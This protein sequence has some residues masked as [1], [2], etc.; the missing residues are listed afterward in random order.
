MQTISTNAFIELI[1][2]KEWSKIE[3]IR[4]LNWYC[5]QIDIEREII[6]LLT[7]RLKLDRECMCVCVWLICKVNIQTRYKTF[8]ALSESMT[9]ENKWTF[10]TVHSLIRSLPLESRKSYYNPYRIAHFFLFHTA[11]CV[12]CSVK[13][14]TVWC[15]L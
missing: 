1:V 13:Q 8:R 6:C 4:T 2:N 10:I 3:P 14:S 12:R 9:A 15:V 7:R 11:Q 5:N